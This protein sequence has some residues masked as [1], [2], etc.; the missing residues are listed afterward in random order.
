MDKEIVK[1]LIQDELNT[2]NLVQA[3][4]SILKNN[5]AQE[6]LKEEYSKLYQLLSAGGHASKNASNL[7][8]QFLKPSII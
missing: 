2:A 8:M 5:Q 1:E 7:I 3:L 4:N 6:I